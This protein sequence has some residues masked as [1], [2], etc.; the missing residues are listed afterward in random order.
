[1]RWACAPWRHAGEEGP[2]AYVREALDLLKVERI[3]HGV[4]SL[5]DRDLMRR[6]AAEQ[7]PLHPLSP[8]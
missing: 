2:A 4:R 7:V 8:I 1:M 3:D 5:E 6:L